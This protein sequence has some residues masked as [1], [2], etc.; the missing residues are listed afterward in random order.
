MQKLSDF[1]NAHIDKYVTT[2]QN[3]VFLSLRHW[4]KS[5]GRAA[6]GDEKAREIQRHSP[7]SSSE[8]YGRGDIPALKD[9]IDRISYDALPLSKIQDTFDLASKAGWKCG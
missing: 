9:G 3:L 5:K 6:M 2:N 7:Q 4:F 1:L 8:G